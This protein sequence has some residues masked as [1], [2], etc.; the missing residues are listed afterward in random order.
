[1]VNTS[2]HDWIPVAKELPPE[3][4]EVETKI[5]DDSGRRNQKTMTLK[6][7][8]WFIHGGAMY[9]YYTPTHWRPLPN[10]AARG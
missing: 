9:V 8:L 4:V 2:E 1:M 7:R 3:G 5:D 6:V 10:I